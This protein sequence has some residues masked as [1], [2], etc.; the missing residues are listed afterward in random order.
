[1]EC[2][3]PLPETFV[4]QPTSTFPG[5]QGLNCVQEEKPLVG[6]TP[7]LKCRTFRFGMVQRSTLHKRDLRKERKECKMVKLRKT[8]SNKSR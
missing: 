8:L 2:L 1:M 7:R 3:S 6:Q 5:F 4:A